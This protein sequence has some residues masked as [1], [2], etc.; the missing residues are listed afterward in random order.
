MTD[1]MLLY[2]KAAILSGFFYKTNNFIIHSRIRGGYQ[3]RLPSSA[4]FDYIFLNNTIL[5]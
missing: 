5:S 2:K 3:S 1:L 4:P